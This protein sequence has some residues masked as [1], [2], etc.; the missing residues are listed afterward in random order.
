VLD[1]VRPAQIL[2]TNREASDQ[3][4]GPVGRALAAVRLRHPSPRRYRTPLSRTKMLRVQICSSLRYAPSA[5][6]NSSAVGKSLS[7]KNFIAVSALMHPYV[8][9]VRG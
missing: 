8:R 9:D 2:N 5:S 6:G 1:E 7:Q 3:A 4:N